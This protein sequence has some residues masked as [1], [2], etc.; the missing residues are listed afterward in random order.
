MNFDKEDPKQVSYTTI[1]NAHTDQEN[2]TQESVTRY[3]PWRE[4]RLGWVL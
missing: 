4:L 3:R 2:E 1:V